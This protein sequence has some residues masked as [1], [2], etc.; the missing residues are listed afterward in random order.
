VNDRITALEDH[1]LKT[2]QT[3]F[4]AT[5]ARIQ[6]FLPEG[7]RFERLRR[8]A[9]ALESRYPDPPARPP[10]Y[11]MP[12]GVKDI[13]HVAGM[14]T[15]A[16]SRLPSHLFAGPEAECVTQL[17]EAG[18]L[19]LGKTVTTEFAYFGPG[20]TRNPHNPDHTPGG[21]SSGSAAAVAADVC[22][23]ALGTQTIGSI[24]RPAAYCGVLGFK[25]TSRRISTAG[26][27]PLSPT[28]DHIGYFA[29]DVALAAVVA[30][31]L[32]RDWD[33]RKSE[34]GP[35]VLGVPLGPYLQKA[36][37]EALD[38]FE[39][40]QSKLEQAGFEIR[41]VEAMLNFDQI[42]EQTVGLVAAEAAQVHREW[43]AQYADLYHPKT[44]ALIRQGQGVTEQQLARYRAGR[45]TF[46][47]QIEELMDR[48]GISAWISPPAQGTAPPTLDST[49]DPVM[50]L[51][52]TYAGLPVINLP[53]GFAK[54]GLPFGLQLVAGW[55]QDEKLLAWADQIA[56]IPI[57]GHNPGHFVAGNYPSH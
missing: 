39:A 16:G 34:S 47:A 20:P 32:C 11:G 19:V 48:H 10:L 40:I 5:N 21:S 28:L 1:E 43:F 22:P 27:I 50:N 36:G 12:V 49:G 2:L 9:A 24:I 51:P 55:N 37:P 54:N 25:P 38:H 17:K 23:L 7:G 8:E 52:W 13:F 4:E 45:E 6:A 30:N 14:S 44:T 41:R 56:K 29:R 3:Q 35:P 15:Q 33:S 31:I 57:L 46:R 53:A 18:A 26:V 42:V